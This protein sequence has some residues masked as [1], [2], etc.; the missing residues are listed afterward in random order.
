MDLTFFLQVAAAGRYASRHMRQV[1]ADTIGRA[2]QTFE[3]HGG[4]PEGALPED[5]WFQARAQ[6]AVQGL[7][8]RYSNQASPGARP[9]LRMADEPPSPTLS[10]T[11][12]IDSRP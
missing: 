3:E 7:V 10:D 6:E 2:K 4:D 9:P 5:A 11:S 8:S 12:S 1:V